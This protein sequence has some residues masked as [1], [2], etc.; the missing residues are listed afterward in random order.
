MFGTDSVQLVQIGNCSAFKIFMIMA[1][2]ENVSE[3][4]ATT[5]SVPHDAAFLE[6]LQ[7]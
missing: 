7:A 5:V 4:C 6:R 2:P 3:R 1:K